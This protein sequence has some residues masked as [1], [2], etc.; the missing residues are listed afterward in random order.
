MKIL[1]KAEVNK[2][3][4]AAPSIIFV[5]KREKCFFECQVKKVTAIIFRKFRGIFIETV[6]FVNTNSHSLTSQKRKFSIKD[7]FT[8]CDEIRRKLCSASNIYWQIF[9]LTRPSIFVFVL[10]FYITKRMISGW[11]VSY[12]IIFYIF[13]MLIALT[14]ISER[15][16][17]ISSSSFYG[18][19]IS[20]KC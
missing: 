16:R 13:V 3:S 10:Y 2:D 14:K 4:I 6:Q 12:K 1:A 5:A 19:Y 11:Q 17:S 15:E 18:P 9:H 7:F 8:K 20:H